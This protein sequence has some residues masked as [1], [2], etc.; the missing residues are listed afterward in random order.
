MTNVVSIAQSGANNV[1]MRNRIINGSMVIDQRNNGAVTTIAGGNVQGFGTDRFTVYSAT[2]AITTQRSS[3]AP[4]GFVN[5][6]LYTQSGTGAVAATDIGLIYQRIEGYN[7]ADLGWGTDTA[8]TVTISFWVRSSLT[9]TFGFTLLNLAQNRRFTT[10]YTINS[11]N[12]FE[13]KTLT[14]IGDTTGTWLTDNSTGVGLYWDMGVGSTYSTTAGSTWGTGIF[15]GLTGGTKVCATTG[16]TFYITGVQLEKGTVATP[17]EQRLYGTELSLC[18]RYLNV[19]RGVSSTQLPVCSG[20][21]RSTTN[22][23]GVFKLP[24]TMRTAPSLTSSN[25]TNH[26]HISAG[27]GDFDGP[28]VGLE[29]GTYV[30]PDVIALTMNATT[31]STTI[32]LGASLYINATTSA[33]LFFVAEL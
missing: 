15:Y 16:A 17:F 21:M 32:G 1:T 22:F 7:I 30:S 2:N 19:L 28:T 27:N 18:Q 20:F 6:L 29:A 5:S 3:T 12:T 26:F 25:S 11:A 13:Y 23:V 4:T 33:F 10:S 14:I 9:G 8:Q 24:V 31:G